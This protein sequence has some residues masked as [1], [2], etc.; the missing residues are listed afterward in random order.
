M[1]FM[2]DGDLEKLLLRLEHV[3]KHYAHQ[4]I[5]EF[6]KM[7]ASLG[8]IIYESFDDVRGVFSVGYPHYTFDNYVPEQ[9]MNWFHEKLGFALEK[10]ED[11]L[12]GKIKR[13]YEVAREDIDLFIVVDTHESLYKGK[14][15][16]DVSQEALLYGDGKVFDI[17]ALDKVVQRKT[18]IRLHVYEDPDKN[19]LVIDQTII[20]K[21]IWFNLRKNAKNWL[22][23][24]QWGSLGIDIMFSMVNL[25][26]DPE[27]DFIDEFRYKVIKSTLGA[28]P[29][30][31]VDNIRFLPH[32]PHSELLKDPIVNGNWKMRM[33][34]SYTSYLTKL[35]ESK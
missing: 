30:E 5:G 28:T 25:A 34:Q 9:L 29:S 7:I 4:D 3:R 24:E 10:C 8:S 26:S 19:E 18:G 23:T 33:L 17:V 31:K 21:N 12:S 20:P 11:D 32:T 35:Q 2:A 13:A 27:Y 1:F 6:R 15:F 16:K 22:K 14:C